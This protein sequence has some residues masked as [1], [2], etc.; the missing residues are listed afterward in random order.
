M[1]PPL[2]G[3]V[4]YLFAFDVAD[5][6]RTEKVSKI[7]SKKAMPFTIPLDHTLP[8]DM[9]F[10]T[11]L[12]IEPR[13]HAWKL[14]GLPMNIVVRIYDVGVVSLMISVPFEV[15]SV[16]ELIKFHEPTLDNQRPLDAAAH[17]LCTDIVKNLQEYIVRGSEKVGTPEPY[18]VFTFQEAG[19]AV[20][21]GPWVEEHRQEIA[22]LLAETDAE[23]LSPQQV[24]ETFRQSISFSQEDTTI[25]D[26]DSAFVI[27]LSGPP[28]DILHVL[29]LANLQLEELVLMD[30]RL[31][32]FLDRAYDD[33]EATRFPFFGFFRMG[34]AKLRRFRMD[35]TKIT[36]DVSNISKF[37]GDWY[38]AR[39]YLA[40]RERFHLSTW[41]ESIQNRL[42]HLDH[43]YEVLRAETNES[44]MLVLEFLI[45][46][47]FIIDLVAVFLR[48]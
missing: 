25:I 18:T 46:L 11:P 44:R 8:K 23:K 10:Y 16:K 26:W 41:K 12:T 27:D 36:D 32:R 17:D 43:L 42:S 7:L 30:Q 22:G 29:E 45:V 2:K 4:V 15:S 37:F 19:G 33:L 1:A 14:G 13:P 6:I 3:E 5:E 24:E 40:A 39:V 35:V 48:N 9:P 38:L 47:L 28:K 34:L 20:N 21:T 31:D